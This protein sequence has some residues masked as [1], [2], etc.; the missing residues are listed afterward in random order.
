MALN[1]ISANKIPVNLTPENNDNYFNVDNFTIHDSSIIEGVSK[2]S[3]NGTIIWVYLESLG[4]NN[5][6]VTQIYPDENN[7][8]FNIDP[9]RQLPK[10]MYTPIRDEHG[11]TKTKSIM[12]LLTESK[13]S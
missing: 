6:K 7:K 8:F 10:D 1:E 11:K 5:F 4:N 3:V 9:T 2:A 12:E 13:K